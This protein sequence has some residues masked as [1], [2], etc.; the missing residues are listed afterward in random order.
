AQ[1]DK[2]SNAADRLVS[3]FDDTNV[4]AGDI[5]FRPGHDN[6][7]LAI[8]YTKTP[9]GTTPAE[10]KAIYGKLNEQ[11][12]KFEFFTEDNGNG[13]KVTNITEVVG[14]DGYVYYRI[15]AD[16][17]ANGSTVTVIGTNDKDKSFE[18]IGS[19]QATDQVDSKLASSSI[20]SDVDDTTDKAIG[21]VS[22][23]QA[24]NTSDIVIS[25]ANNNAQMPDANKVAVKFDPSHLTPEAAR[26]LGLKVKTEANGTETVVKD[27]FIVAVKQPNGEWTLHISDAT[28]LEDA[29]KTPA[30]ERANVSPTIATV[31]ANGT[32]T[33]KKDVVK[34]KS[35]VIAK[36]QDP[37]GNT[38]E[39]NQTTSHSDPA[40]ADKL[41]VVDAPIIEALGFGEV[42]VS[43]GANN[44]KVEISGL[45]TQPIVITKN[46][47]TYSITSPAGTNGALP[48]GVKAFDPST[49]KITLTSDTAKEITATGKK[50]PQGNNTPADAVTKHNI[51]PNYDPSPDT[52]DP[53]ESITTDNGAVTIKPGVDNTKLTVT[54]RDNDGNEQTVTFTKTG[55]TWAA[56][57]NQDHFEIDQAKGTITLKADKVKDMT[58]VTAKAANATGK[59]TDEVSATPGVNDTTPSNADKPT[60]STIAKSGDPVVVNKGADNIKFD[61]TYTPKPATGSQGTEKTITATLTEGGEWK[62][63]DS[64]GLPVPSSLAT[65]DKNSGKVTITEPLAGN[66]QV[67]AKGYDNAHTADADNQN[68][69]ADPPPPSTGG[70]TSGSPTAPQKET[71]A[72]GNSA[73]DLNGGDTLPGKIEIPSFNGYT[74]AGDSTRGEFRQTNDKDVYVLLPQGSNKPDTGTQ[75]V[76]LKVYSREKD[77]VETLRI[78]AH[79]ENGELKGYTYTVDNGSPSV[80]IRYDVGAT[81]G[82]PITA[83][84]LGYL[85]VP[86]VDSNGK[87]T[88]NFYLLSND[89]YRLLADSPEEPRK[90]G[91]YADQSNL[92]IKFFKDGT[93]TS[94]SSPGV[95]SDYQ[96]FEGN[97][98]FVP[99]YEVP[100]KGAEALVQAEDPALDNN[101]SG[102]QGAVKID[103]KSNTTLLVNYTN[104][105]GEKKSA[106]LTKNG[107]TWNVTEGDANDFEVRVHNGNASIIIK[108]DA[109]LDN[110]T[111][112]V[113]VKGT[114]EGATTSNAVK[115]T[116]QADADAPV[117]N[118]GSSGAGNG[119]TGSSTTNPVS[120]KPTTPEPVRPAS[121][122]PNTALSDAMNN[123]QSNPNA[124]RIYGDLA[125]RK[126]LLF[127]Y[128]ANGVKSLDEFMK[129]RGGILKT[130]GN[131][132]DL[133]KYSFGNSDNVLRIN[134]SVGTTS[135]NLAYRSKGFELDM[136]GGDDVVTI[137]N[138]LGSDTSLARTKVDLGDGHDVLAIGTANDKFKL[139]VNPNETDISKR[140]VYDFTGDG[141]SQPQ[142]YTLVKNIGETDKE[143]G[144]STL[145]NA[146]QQGGRIINADVVGGN[147]N[148]A[149]IIDGKQ[150]GDEAAIGSGS[151]I[152]LGEGDDSLIIAP[153]PLLDKAYSNRGAIAGDKSGTG[154]APVVDMGSG[155]DYLTASGIDHGAKVYMGSGNDIVDLFFFRGTN[156]V[157]DMG[158]GDDKVIIKG[159]AS[160]GGTINLG[161]GNDRI[162][163]TVGSSAFVGQSAEFTAKVD[164][165]AGYDVFVLKRP[166]GDGGGFVGSVF[167]NKTKTHLSTKELFNIEEIR[168]EQG[169]ALDINAVDLRSH[170][171]SKLKIIAEGNQAKGTVAGRDARLV[172]LSTGTDSDGKNNSGDTQNLGDFKKDAQTQT[173]Y[174]ITYDVYRAGTTEVWIQKDYFTV[175]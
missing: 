154:Q 17:V 170:G 28:S 157:L 37:Y 12:G 8:S 144:D 4:N 116:P 146:Y 80:N 24:N 145:A 143:G 64:D 6:V 115:T 3:N 114:K 82:T 65:I 110:A 139:Y 163:F 131:K 159:E 27:Q 112:S 98:A 141:E 89:K 152:N 2:D 78:T 158:A 19:N 136:Q 60:I 52:V 20:T 42:A 169:T 35:E 140:Y 47:D 88:T 122:T 108:A 86:E 117:D 32:I 105:K 93:Q 40:D 126:G 173:E 22:I 36:A 13:Q 124:G 142:G 83:K 14:Q 106:T 38:S 63:T 138:Y 91:A 107:D 164:G 39:Q 156:S 43:P 168:M 97:N 101:V 59:E 113:I 174:G 118:S 149:V 160:N 5:L 94:Y 121:A 34:G 74:G 84:E 45:N 111:D 51:D 109:L 171:M 18:G 62:L 72:A 53:I 161:A 23:N 16:E 25:V 55:K 102:S 99:R 9:V 130:G 61:V 128:P 103:P 155:N 104:E 175:I 132:D 33:L 90:G 172:D 96:N 137:L 150:Y 77:T 10:E 100:P 148:D 162:E 87:L 95:L 125:E 73:G 56:D 153:H 123:I 68:V 11:T 41:V 120:P 135:D 151:N 50:N 79:Y 70:S 29:L 48:D 75:T 49:G 57:K 26:T 44:D 133:I 167:A 15:P 7:K 119:N 129:S 147:G 69:P 30:G 92:Y 166:T 71:G 1:G 67:K 58:E 46:G 66:S 31:D 134:G 21:N 127:S 54:Y 85:L 76:A 81:G 165:G